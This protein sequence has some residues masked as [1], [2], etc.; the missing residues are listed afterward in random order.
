MLLVPITEELRVVQVVVPEETERAILALQEL[1]AK[2]ML[3]DPFLTPVV[4]V[5]VVEQDQQEQMADQI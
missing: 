2:D 4:P 3:V 5:A 1:L